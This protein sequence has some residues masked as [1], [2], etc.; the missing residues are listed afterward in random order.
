MKREN[1]KSWIY[2]TKKGWIKSSL[3]ISVRRVNYFN[4]KLALLDS[5]LASA[6]A[7]STEVSSP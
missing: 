3:L 7:L 6:E 4:S 1:R 2:L 5:C